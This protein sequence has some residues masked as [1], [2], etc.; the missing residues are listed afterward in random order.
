MQSFCSCTQV[1]SHIRY[2]FSRAWIHAHAN[3]YCIHKHM[4]PFY[5]TCVKAS[6]H[7]Y[8]HTTSLYVGSLPTIASMC[9]HPLFMEWWWQ[10][11]II[12]TCI[13]AVLTSLLIVRWNKRPVILHVGGLIHTILLTKSAVMVLGQQGFHMSP[14]KIT[15]HINAMA[16]T[17][18]VTFWL[19]SYKPLP[20][21]LPTPQ[22]R[23]GKKLLL[24]L[25]NKHTFK[26][27]LNIQYLHSHFTF[28]PS[29]LRNL[30]R[31]EDMI[32]SSLLKRLTLYWTPFWT[33]QRN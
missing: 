15:W 6:I 21:S 16:P 2:M 25:L 17:T 1:H 19:S 4:L 30:L 8:K 20:Y 31:T 29:Q 14:I 22:K 5:T 32:I 23:N 3:A 28:K 12:M 24:T 11:I 10:G 33:Q 7:A 27:L 26:P 13:V 9:F 18:T